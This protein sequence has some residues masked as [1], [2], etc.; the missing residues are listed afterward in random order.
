MSTSKR[1]SLANIQAFLSGGGTQEQLSGEKYGK[2]LSSKELKR[3]L[4]KYARNGTI[5]SSTPSEPINPLYSK[6]ISSPQL[7]ALQS[8]YAR[9]L[10]PGTGETEANTQLQNVIAS[11]ELGIAKSEQEPMAQGF[12]TGQT[13][14]LEKSAALKALPLQTKL[15]NLQSQRFAAADVLKASLGFEAEKLSGQRSA[16][17]YQ[18][19]LAEQQKAS[20][21]DAAYAQLAAAKQLKLSKKAIARLKAQIEAI[22]YG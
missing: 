15:A 18:T 16:Y 10:T 11:K 12:V 19:S 9:T 13:S 20:R 1:K 3:L 6:Y 2:K 14:A 7:E 22:Q 5:A 8:Q 17:E 4:A 21:L